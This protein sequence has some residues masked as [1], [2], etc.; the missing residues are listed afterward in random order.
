MAAGTCEHED[1]IGVDGVEEEPVGLNVQ[2][3]GGQKAAGELVVAVL[4]QPVS[5]LFGDGPDPGP[6]RVHLVMLACEPFHVAKEGRPVGG[7]TH[8]R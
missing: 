8:G 6:E 5:P 7:L 4:L 1:P 3:T 2:L